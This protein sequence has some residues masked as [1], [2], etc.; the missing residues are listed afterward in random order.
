MSGTTERLSEIKRIVTEVALLHGDF[1]LSSGAKS[2]YYVDGRIFTTR[3]DGAY[4]IGKEIFER[5]AEKEVDAVGGLAI[6][7]VPIAIAVALVSHLEG[8]PIPAFIVRKEAKEHGT[9]RKIEG[10]LPPKGGR[11]AIIDDVNTTGDSVIEAIEAV[12]AAGCQ[13][14]KV[15][16]L[17]DRHQGGSDKL[18]ERGYDFSSI[19]SSDAQGEITID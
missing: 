1:T 16:A 7:G 17:L 14:V 15:I 9:R 5:L 3:P 11:V 8:K 13:V 6:G 19:L 18:R 12:E 10:N 2:S 4:L